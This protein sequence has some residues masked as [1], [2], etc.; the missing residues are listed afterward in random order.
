MKSPQ[1]VKVECVWAK[2][3]GQEIV[4]L[5]H[6]TRQ[7][8]KKEMA[9]EH[10]ERYREAVQDESVQCTK[11]GSL[12]AKR[13][14]FINLNHLF[15]RIEVCGLQEA[16]YMAVLG[17]RSPDNAIKKH[18]IR[19][20]NFIIFL[21]KEKVMPHLYIYYVFIICGTPTFFSFCFCLQTW[22]E[23]MLLSDKCRGGHHWRWHGP[24]TRRGRT[25]DLQLPR[26]VTLQVE[27]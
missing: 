24:L 18:F 27:P 13:I 14:W 20:N 8:S 10:Q 12:V 21:K 6:S 5:C 16:L 7:S 4:I 2:K 9:C 26:R 23:T 11:V 1:G 22:A 17:P 3:N 15:R 19:N 25:G